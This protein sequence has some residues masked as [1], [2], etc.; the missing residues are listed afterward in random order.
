MAPLTEL[1]SP[2][3]LPPGRHP[4]SGGTPRAGGVQEPR[5]IDAASR[6]ARPMDLPHGQEYQTGEVIGRTEGQLQLRLRRPPHRNRPPGPGRGP[7][8]GEAPLGRRGAQ[9]DELRERGSVHPCRVPEG[10]GDLTVRSSTGLLHRARRRRLFAPV[11]RRGSRA[12]VGR[13]GT[14]AAVAASMDRSRWDQ[15]SV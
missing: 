7:H 10:L 8:R 1:G 2:F 9:G 6:V 5:R 13:V 3:R 4:P 11:G 12:R 15:N 14:A